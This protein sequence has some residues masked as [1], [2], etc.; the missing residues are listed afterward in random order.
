MLSYT[1][2]D[3]SNKQV[4]NNL[5]LEDIP[6]AVEAATN[7]LAG[8]NSGLVPALISL[9]V[10][11]HDA[12]DLTLIDLPGIVRVPIGDQPADIVKQIKELIHKHIAGVF[13]F[14]CQVTQ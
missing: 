4:S 7:H 2:P 1:D 6:A 5:A 12:P 11:T 3:D 8:T 13:P 10:T 14:G 9:R